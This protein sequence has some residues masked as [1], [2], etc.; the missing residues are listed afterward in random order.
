M[1]VLYDI[2]VANTSSQF[3]CQHTQLGEH[4]GLVIINSHCLLVL[5]YLIT[6]YFYLFHEVKISQSFINDKIKAL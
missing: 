6:K 5:L 4:S 2:V 1:Y 3:I